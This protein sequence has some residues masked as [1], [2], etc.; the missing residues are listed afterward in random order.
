MMLASPNRHDRP[1]NSF[2]HARSPIL[3]RAYRDALLSLYWRS[4]RRCG[5]MTF[6]KVHGA[7]RSGTNYLAWMLR[8]NFCE[9]QPLSIV[10]GWKHGP[11]RRIARR[12]IRGAGRIRG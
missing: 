11:L 8:N 4:R 5:A 12:S 6:V 1:M 3:L 9:V 10:L 7:M 2:Y